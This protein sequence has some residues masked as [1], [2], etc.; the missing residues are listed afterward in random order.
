MEFRP[1]SIQHVGVPVSDMQ[2]SLRFY[3]EMLGLTPDFVA[4][5][6]GAELSQAVGVPDT[7][8]SFAFLKIGGS[9]LELLEYRNPRGR[10]YDRRNCDVGAIHIAFEVEDI[11]EAYDTLR[12]KGVDFKSPPLN[13]GEGPLAGCSFAYFE[14]PDGIQLEIFEVGS[15]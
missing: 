11:Q 15:A 6:S 1:S 10:A 7:D 4:D 14:D 2:R 5:G 12:A 9:T 13:I 8:L 3:R